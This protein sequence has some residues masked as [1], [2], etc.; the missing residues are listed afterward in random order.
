VFDALYSQ[1]D[2]LSQWSAERLRRHIATPATEAGAL[3]VFYGSGT[4]ELSGALAT[5]LSDPVRR[6]PA[7]IARFYRV[8]AL[9]QR[10][11]DIPGFAGPTL[12][13]DASADL[14]A[15]R[16]VAPPRAQAAA[17]ESEFAPRSSTTD[18]VFDEDAAERYGIP[19]GLFRYY[20][21]ANPR[22]RAL[23]QRARALSTDTMPERSGWSGSHRSARHSRRG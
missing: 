4:A 8:E 18:P 9:S 14:P 15:P 19:L 5:A 2:G 6:A 23:S 11:D 21:P 22:T 16:R 17:A 13:A 7:A 10:H 12:L 3:R 1:I 20:A